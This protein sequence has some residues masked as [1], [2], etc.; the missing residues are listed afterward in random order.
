MSI[1]INPV[2]RSQFLNQ[3][4][5][6]FPQESCGFILGVITG[7][8]SAIGTY[9]YPCE[10]QKQANKQRRFLIDPD[11]Y[12]LVEDTADANGLAIVSIVHSHPNHPDQPSEF[13]KQHAWPGLSY[14]IVSVYEGQ[15]RGYRSWRL[16]DDRTAFHQETINPGG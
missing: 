15:V 3:A 7:S 5:R 16:E 13:D 2:I 9:Y 14:I 6:C 12:Q 4:E 11:I 1:E 10:N 8:D